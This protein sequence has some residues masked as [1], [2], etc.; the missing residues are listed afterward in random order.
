M[1]D[2]MVSN[3]PKGDP[4]MVALLPE[5]PDEAVSNIRMMLTIVSKLSLNR[6]FSLYF[7]YPIIFNCQSYSRGGDLPWTVHEQAT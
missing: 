4:P 5:S 1:F 7:R 6:R 3:A 2:G